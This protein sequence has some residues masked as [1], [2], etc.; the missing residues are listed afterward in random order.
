MR[1]RLLIV[2]DDDLLGMSLV[3]F[4][5]G[6]YDVKLCRTY[7]DARDI[8]LSEAFDIA[9]LDVNLPDGE[10]TDLLSI[11]QH[12]PGGTE[13][14]V[15][16]AY[17]EVQMAV[18]TLKMGA[19]D[20]VNKPFDLEDLNHTVK[21]ALEMKL[22]KQKLYALSQ[23]GEKSPLESFIG[24]SELIKKMK[25]DILTAASSPDTR[26]LITGDTGTGKEL[27][28]SAIHSL[29]PRKDRPFVTINSAGIPEQLVESELFG[30]TEGAF[31]D[32]KKPKKG[33]LEMASGGT[34]FFDEA[35]DLPMS[36]QVK[37]LRFLETGAFYKLG[38]TVETRVNV[39][40]ISA[41][42]KDLK[43][44]VKDGSFREDLYFRLNVINIQTPSL[45]ARGGDITDIAEHYLSEYLIKMNKQPFTLSDEDKRALTEYTWPGNVRELKNVMERTALYGCMPT[46]DGAAS[47]RVNSAEDTSEALSLKEME[48]RHILNVY[49][50][51]DFNKTKAADILG[52]SRLTLRKKLSE[53]G[54][55]D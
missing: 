1:N 45:R 4:F 26:V 41:T 46:L 54:I 10:G 15:V 35:G 49:R 34:I 16:T 14:V 28:A 27:V 38:S 36:T 55:E 52:V 29:S 33:L 30:Y 32:A 12:S 40:V 18:K 7:N 24:S 19:Y 11:L 20:Y 21:K 3:K 39:R 8:L 43:A 2:E 17:P 22:A 44:A 50:Q 6:I 51:A 23:N 53:Y 37:L 31:T 9:L 5:S 42:N 47:C 25:E 13:A 48:K